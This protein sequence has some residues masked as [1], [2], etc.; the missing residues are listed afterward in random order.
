MNALNTLPSNELVGAVL[1]ILIWAV[2]GVLL[3]MGRMVPELLSAGAVLTLGYYFRAQSFNAG[4][5][6]ALKSAPKDGSA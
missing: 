4:V 5:D 2:V 1:A 3:I 6:H